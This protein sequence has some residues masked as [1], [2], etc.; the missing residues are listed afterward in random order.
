MRGQKVLQGSR[1]SCREREKPQ[2]GR[3]R[4][5]L[6]AAT[7]ISGKC[8]SL[9]KNLKG[10]EVGKN[11]RDMFKKGDQDD[12]GHTRATERTRLNKVERGETST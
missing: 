6:N 11:G 8:H 9:G 2:S 1:K 12:Q 7:D 5:K 10:K 4:Y 3:G